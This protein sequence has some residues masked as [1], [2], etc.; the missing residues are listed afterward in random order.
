[1]KVVKNY[2]Y[3]AFY[4]IFV[5]LVPLVTTPYLSRVLGPQGVGI[6]SYTNSIIQ[7]FILAGSIGI[8]MYGNRQIAFVRDNKEEL[9]KTFYEIFFLRIITIAIA[10]VFFIVF[11]L[12]TK[13]Y[14]LYYIAQSISII[15][16]AFD[17]SWF[18]MGVENFA[19]T[20]FRNLVI[21]ILSLIC[22]FTFVKSFG[23]LFIYIAI[24][25]LSLL[26]GNLTLFPS[27][28]R[29]VGKVDWKKLNV[30]KHLAPSISLFIPQIAIQIYLVVNKTMLGSL[31]SVVAAGY[32]DQSDKVVKLVL[33][34]VTA[35]GTVMLPHVA[36]AYMRGD[37]AKTKQSL[38]N[39]FSFVTAL[40]V[41]MMFGLM[42][43]AKKFVPLF[44]SNK[45]RAII[46]LMQMESIVILIIAWGSALGV[47]YLL[48]TNQNKSYTLSV[49]LGAIVNIVINVPLILFLGAFGSTIAT[50]CSEMAV[51]GYQLFAIRQQISYKKLFHDFGKYMLAG[52]LM[53][54]CVVFLDN[55]LS[56]SWIS[57]GLEVVMGALIYLGMLLILKV[58]ILGE[59]KKVLKE[60]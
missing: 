41:P 20:I 49:V 54:V 11:L 5:L 26:F 1:M 22:I 15:A 14:R 44:F 24:L 60:K 48:P 47:Q 21:K 37:I 58:D 9:T 32:F 36:N 17:I 18:F 34:I 38:Y 50:V 10:Y 31:D 12:L 29:Y 13:E 52:F 8:G 2:L 43:V 25:S 46:P 51:S 53:F 39:S 27:L 57:L 33:A 42:A 6:N 55:K 19:V 3:N 23:D 7:Y 30:L 35:T 59:A 28:K 40:S 4:Q 45:F 16:A 56:C